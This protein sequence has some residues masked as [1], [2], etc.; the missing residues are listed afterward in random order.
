MSSF[1][2]CFTIC[3][4]SQ[5]NCNWFPLKFGNYQNIKSNTSSEDNTNFLKNDHKFLVPFLNKFLYKSGFFMTPFH[6]FDT[7]GCC[8]FHLCHK[9]LNSDLQKVAKNWTK[10]DTSFFI[11]LD[12]CH[13]TLQSDNLSNQLTVA[14]SHQLIHGCTGHVTGCNHW[15]EQMS[16]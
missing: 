2:L 7:I 1:C 3:V 8:C 15:K 9:S 5:E 16:F 11:H 14:H 4:H 13:V 10:K 6:A 12:S